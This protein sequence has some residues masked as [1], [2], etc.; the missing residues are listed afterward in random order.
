MSKQKRI[1]VKNAIIAL[2][3]TERFKQA[4]ELAAA[5]DSCSTSFLIETVMRRELKRRGINLSDIDVE[6]ESRK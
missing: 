3:T 1:A 4:I 5:Q 2:R 6:N